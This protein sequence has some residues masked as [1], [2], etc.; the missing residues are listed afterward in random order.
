[1]SSERSD[2]QRG[3]VWA[4]ARFKSRRSP[5]RSISLGK[6]SA[7]GGGTS[8]R[9]GLVCVSGVSIWAPRSPEA[10]YSAKRPALREPAACGMLA[11]EEAAVDPVQNIGGVGQIFAR[12][13]IAMLIG[14]VI[15]LNRD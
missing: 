8:L 1:M 13:G 7:A 12:L 6:D 5:S 3:Q 11:G 4:T 2:I 9:L 15:G 14:S 10:I